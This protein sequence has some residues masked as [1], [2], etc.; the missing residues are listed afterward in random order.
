MESIVMIFFKKGIVSQFQ[1]VYEEGIEE[2]G[3]ELGLF[4]DSCEDIG[5]VK[6]VDSIER[7][8][9]VEEL[10][11]F[12]VVAQEGIVFVQFFVGEEV[13]YQFFS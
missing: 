6:V 10:F 3:G 13:I 8:E 2:V 1:E 4:I 11:F 12:V 7:E 9:V 5:E